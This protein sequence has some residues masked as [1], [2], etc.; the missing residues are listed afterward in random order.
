MA[1]MLKIR[2]PRL[3]VLFVAGRG[4]EADGEHGF[5]VVHAIAPA[6]RSFLHK[7][8]TGNDLLNKVDHL[9]A[10]QTDPDRALGAA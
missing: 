5:S 6:D 7:P 2:I 8:F 3:K 4:N 9:L 10:G 1:L